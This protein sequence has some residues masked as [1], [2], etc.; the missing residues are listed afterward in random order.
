VKAAPSVAELLAAELGWDH[1]ETARQVADYNKLVAQEQ[2]D[3]G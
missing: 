1:A 3:A 2:A